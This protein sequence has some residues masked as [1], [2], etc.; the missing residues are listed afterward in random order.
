[1]RSV[2]HILSDESKLSDQFWLEPS[3]GQASLEEY[4]T[5]MSRRIILFVI[6]YLILTFVVHFSICFAKSEM[7]ILFCL[8][9]QVVMTNNLFLQYV[10]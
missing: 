4:L 10:N 9:M 2:D 8:S 3:L 7:Y 5:L 6:S 1:M